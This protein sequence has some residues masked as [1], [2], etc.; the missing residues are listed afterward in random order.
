MKV[1]VLPF[2]YIGHI[3]EYGPMFHTIRL[4]SGA[5]I[6]APTA[7]VETVEWSMRK[8]MLLLAA[9]ASLTMT[10]IT[11]QAAIGWNLKLDNS[12]SMD[13]SRSRCDSK[14]VEATLV[15]SYSNIFFPRAIEESIN[16]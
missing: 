3:V 16:V 1:K 12:C 10:A 5:L 2:N 7:F 15:H 9:T 13:P 14:R 4:A 11:S 6:I 8:A